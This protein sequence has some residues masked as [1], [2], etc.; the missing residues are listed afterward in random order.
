MYVCV[1]YDIP[2]NLRYMQHTHTHAVVLL[3]WLWGFWLGD[4]FIL[5]NRVGTP[6]KPH[7]VVAVV[8]VVRINSLR[9]CVCIIPSACVRVLNVEY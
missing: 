1:K 4:V 2:R 6:P 3:T 8:V 9:M 5:T 7:S